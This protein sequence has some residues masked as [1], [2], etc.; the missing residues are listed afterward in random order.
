M[1]LLSGYGR[2]ASIK[3]GHSQASPD[4]YTSKENLVAE[5]ALCT[6][7]FIENLLKRD[8]YAKSAIVAKF[9]YSY[10]EGEVQKSHYNMLRS[11]IY[12]ILD[13]HE[14]FFYHR[15][16]SEYR[17]KTA[18]EERD[19]GD[20]VE[21]HYESFKRIPFHQGITSPRNEFIQL[22]TQ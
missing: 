19:C 4:F 9:F 5:K 1:V 3:T 16:Q 13:Q 6:K 8:S 15:F 2:I 22:S 7:Y 18:L 10:R 11:I 14:A 20:P 17:C 12:D 21:W